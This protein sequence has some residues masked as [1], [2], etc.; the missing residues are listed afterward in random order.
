MK[1]CSCVHW[2]GFDFLI[3]SANSAAASTGSSR[4]PLYGTK[5]S[6]LYSSQ[7]GFDACFSNPCVF[8][9]HEGYFP[10]YL[11]LYVD[12]L[13][14]GCPDNAIADGIRAK[15]AKNFTLNDLGDACY[16]LGIEM[17]YDCEAG[18]LHLCQSQFI[19]RLIEIAQESAYPAKKNKCK[20]DEFINGERFDSKQFRELVGSL[21]N[22]A[23]GTRQDICVS[24]CELSKYLEA[25]TQAHMKAAIRAGIAMAERV[26]YQSRAKHT[27]LRYHFVC[28]AVNEGVLSLEYVQ[29]NQQL[30]DFMMNAPQTPQLV[31]TCPSRRDC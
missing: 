17:D 16:I 29:S 28:D 1:M 19:Q 31:K 23:S 11:V 21:L 25:P 5:P 9:R 6:F 3:Y 13:L 27:D 12:E 7:L 15:L 14:I 2:N 18:T 20:L 4:L 30:S 10:M 26:G 8:V 24:I 22:I